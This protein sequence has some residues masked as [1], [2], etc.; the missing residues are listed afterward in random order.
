MKQLFLA[1]FIVFS[2]CF[3][4]GQ[5]NG[6]RIVNTEVSAFISNQKGEEGLVIFFLEP[7]CPMC[8]KYTFAINA[9]EKENSET[10]KLNFIGIFSGKGI[11]ESNILNYIE[12]YKIQFP[13][14]LD[15]GF[16]VA[17]YLSAKVTPEVFLLDKNDTIFYHGMIDN[18]Y[19]ALGKRRNKPTE[20]YLKDNISSLLNEQTA[21]YFSNEALGCILYKSDK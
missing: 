3:S 14:F 17:D 18:W 4:F 15:T 11:K 7:E 9:I 16:V 12:R 1:V 21:K 10:N 20:N 8:Q 19:Y 13:V 6:V 5:S 2:S